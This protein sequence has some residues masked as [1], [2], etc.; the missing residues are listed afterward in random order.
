[1]QKTEYHSMF[2]GSQLIAFK[3]YEQ[4]IDRGQ[5]FRKKHCPIAHIILPPRLKVIKLNYKFVC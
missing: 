4:S 5:R 1:M 2:R 3:P